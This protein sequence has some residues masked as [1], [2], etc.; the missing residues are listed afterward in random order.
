MG[1][2]IISIFKDACVSDWIQLPDHVNVIHVHTH[3]LRGNYCVQE[4]CTMFGKEDRQCSINIYIFLI[5]IIH[6]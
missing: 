1:A 5:M 4:T 2:S 6:A 3:K